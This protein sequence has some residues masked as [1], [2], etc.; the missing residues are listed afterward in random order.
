MGIRADHQQTIGIVERM[1]VFIETEQSGA[2]GFH[3]LKDSGT[4]A[5]AHTGCSIVSMQP[6][7]PAPAPKVAPSG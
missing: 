3:P 5:S 1:L 2:V 6:P 4:T 7:A